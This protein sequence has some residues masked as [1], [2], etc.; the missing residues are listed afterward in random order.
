MITISVVH[1]SY[2]RP[3]QAFET[4][5]EWLSLCVHPEDVEYLVGLDDNDP[6]LDQYRQLFGSE[7]TTFGRAE[8]NV[9]DS[10]NNVQATN[11]LATIMSPTSELIVSIADDMSPCPR[12]DVELMSRLVG[13][14]NF[15][16]VRFIGVSDGLHGY[17]SDLLYL[18][19]NRAWYNRLGY[20]LC[21][22]Y[23]GVFADNDSHQVARK[24]N[25][26]I[27]APELL[28][29]HRHYTLGLSEVD[30]TYARNNNPLGSERN[31]RVYN[32]RSARGF[33]L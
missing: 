29:Q 15:N 5:K 24:L 21:P 3:A 12:W 31:L 16:T 4:Y 22:E 14:D 11:R 30:A 8:I 18:I 19:V 10:R 1:P 25:C 20:L 17:G 32:G 26:I 27:N 7:S 28:F 13:V 9:G 6:D 23:D 2:G 33:D